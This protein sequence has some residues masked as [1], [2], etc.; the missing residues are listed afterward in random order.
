MKI[1]QIAKRTGISSRSLRH[2][3]KK[4]LISSSRLDNNYREFDESI[5]DA[6]NTIQLY[7]H[8]GLTTDQIRDIMYCPD[9][10]GYDK[11]EDEYCEELL[12]IYE[13][14][15][16][17]VNRQKRALDEAQVRLEKQIKRMKDNREKWVTV[18]GDEQQ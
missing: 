10:K 17:E 15:L 12:Q 6:I 3:E 5:I 4:G 13:T 16:N 8:L 2:Y 18:K 1:S 14:N 7:L 11:K 9:E